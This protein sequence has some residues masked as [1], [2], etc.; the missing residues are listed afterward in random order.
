MNYGGC[1]RCGKLV[2]FNGVRICPS[3]R[4]I[5]LENVKKYLNENG[6]TMSDKLCRDLGIPKKLIVEFVQD[7]SLQ[8]TFF[9]ADDLERLFDEE[10]RKN[11]MEHLNTM[12]DNSKGLEEKKKELKI[13]SKMRFLNRRR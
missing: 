3:C 1:A 10:R 2:A 8:A 9:H 6:K 5:E 12:N 7:G 13:E 4:E 11:L